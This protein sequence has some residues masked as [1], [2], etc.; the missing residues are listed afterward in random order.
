MIPGSTNEKSLGYSATVE[1]REFGMEKHV[2]SFRESWLENLRRGYL[3]IELSRVRLPAFLF[4]LW[5]ANT[6]G[7]NGEVCARCLNALFAD[8]FICFGG[9]ID[10]NIALGWWVRRLP[11]RIPIRFYFRTKERDRCW[12]VDVVSSF[13]SVYR[14]DKPR[15]DVNVSPLQIAALNT[16]DP[17]SN[18]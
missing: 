14:L 1:S 16:R 12:L 4:D 18:R 17:V 5:F 3:T 7:I 6:A 9:T 15:P 10:G 11:R 13:A 8:S 2:G